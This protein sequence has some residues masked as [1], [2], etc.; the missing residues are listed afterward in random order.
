MEKQEQIKSFFVAA[1]IR[2]CPGDGREN[3]QMNHLNWQGNLGQGNGERKLLDY[4][5]A[6][7]SPAQD[8]RGFTRRSA[9]PMTIHL[10]LIAFLESGQKTLR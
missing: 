7:H 10:R 9:I 3:S 1:I 6:Q 4:F 5:P 8:W 2:Q